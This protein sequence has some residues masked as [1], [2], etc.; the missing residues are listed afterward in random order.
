MAKKEF[1][2]IKV[3]PEKKRERLA[4]PLEQIVSTDYTLQIAADYSIQRYL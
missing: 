1:T 4:L 2:T 3:S